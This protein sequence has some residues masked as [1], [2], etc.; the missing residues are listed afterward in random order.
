MNANQVRSFWVAAVAA[1]SM[2]LIAHPAAA[3]EPGTVRGEVLDA[4]S[5]RPLGGAQVSVPGT[6]RG[7][8]ANSN[9]QFL[10][11]NVPSG[12]RTVR[13]ELIGYGVQEHRGRGV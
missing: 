6:G 9:G 7:A 2:T 3:Q 11:L 12:T 10:V 8:L 13:V 4:V 1:L 5:M